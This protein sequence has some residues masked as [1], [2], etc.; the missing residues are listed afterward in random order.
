MKLA[1]ICPTTRFN[2][3]NEEIGSSAWNM[4]DLKWMHGYFRYGFCA[5]SSFS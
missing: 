4:D 5:T 2:D 1:K 3:K